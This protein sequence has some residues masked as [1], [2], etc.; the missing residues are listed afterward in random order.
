[1]AVRYLNAT[2]TQSLINTIK[3]L[4]AQKTDSSTT[5][6]LQQQLNTVAASIPTKTSQLTND[7]DFLSDEQ[8]ETKYYTQESAQTLAALVEDNQSKIVTL[9]A[10]DTTEG[11]VDYKIKQAISGG[12]IESITTEEIDSLFD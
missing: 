7:S 2:G 9:N 5:S 11:S 10:D 12:G 1:M 3:Q 8:A 4:L 6:Y